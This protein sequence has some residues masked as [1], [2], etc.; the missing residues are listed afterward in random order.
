[1][2]VLKKKSGFL[3]WDLLG[4]ESSHPVNVVRGDGSWTMYVYLSSY[5][6]SEEKDVRKSLFNG[7]GEEAYQEFVDNHFIKFG[8][9]EPDDPERHKMYLDGMPEIKR[10]I[11]EE[12]VQGVRNDLDPIDSDILEDDVCVVPTIQDMYD[13]SEDSEVK[14]K[15]SH[16]LN[17]GQAFNA[18]YENCVENRSSEELLEIEMDFDEIGRIYNSSIERVEGFLVGNVVCSF[19]NKEKWI[20]KIPFEYKFAAV[21]EAFKPALVE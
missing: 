18:A 14:F 1:M 8:G 19:S 12:C 2:N 17:M 20:H 13:P 5:S 11:Y 21:D 4:S 10:F 7:K 9:V 16:Y 3:F 6:N 15:S